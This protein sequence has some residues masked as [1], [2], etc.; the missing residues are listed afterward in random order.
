VGGRGAGKSFVGAYDL[1]RRARPGRL[2]MVAAPTYPMLRDSSIRAFES[3]ARS[4]RYLREF[5][6]GDMRAV[7]GNGAEIL[8]R[9]ADEPERLRGPNLSGAWLDEAS[10]MHRDAYDIVIA[11]LREAGEQGW[12]SATFT[13]KGRSHWTY[14]VFG[15]ADRPNVELFHASTR[16]NP[17]LPSSF[18][19]TLAGQYTSAFASQEIDG[20]FV[21]L[22]GS[23][24]QRQWF[25]LVDHAPAHATSRVR[26]WD[27]AASERTAADYTVGTLMSVSDGIYTIEHVIREKTGPAGVEALL[28]Q[29]A[30]MDGV[31]VPI[32]LEQEGG[33]SGKMIAASFIRMLAGYN[34]RSVRPSADK[35]T[36]AMPLFAQA[37]A[38]NVRLASGP[39]VKSWLD[40]VTQFPNGE[41][42][43]QVDS[44][45]SAFSAL[46]KPLPTMPYPIG[47]RMRA[48]VHTRGTREVIA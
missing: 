17:F 15:D 48:A 21:D 3:F 16:D 35:V 40:E 31:Q 38:G 34:V 9:S 12:L 26:A 29:T 7:L 27:F 39:W 23:I 32:V 42:D 13:P 33:S 25:P 5:S 10:I 20:Q 22:R 28:R 36:R 4:I 6:K 37:Q 8:F 18:A 24:A 11:C 1:I 14:D 19:D 41:H 2:Y 30:E 46:A 43:D 47:G 44:A 45:S